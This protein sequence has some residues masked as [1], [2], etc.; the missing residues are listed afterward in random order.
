VKIKVEVRTNWWTKLSCADCGKD[1]GTV[2]PDRS[3]FSDGAEHMSDR[4]KLAILYCILR[5]GGVV[6]LEAGE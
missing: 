2:Q 1:H 6:E 4:D 3:R 5:G